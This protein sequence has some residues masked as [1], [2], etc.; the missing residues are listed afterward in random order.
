MKRKIEKRRGRTFRSYDVRKD[1]SAEQLAAVG[2]VILAWNDTE[3][4]LNVLMCVVCN[5]H[6]GIWRDLASRIQGYEGKIELVK[7]TV[8]A[9][10]G[11]REN[12]G[13]LHDAI[14]LTLAAVKQGR[15]HRDTL[16]HTRVIDRYLGI[17]ETSVRRT[18]LQEILLT[19]DALNGLYDHI[20]A[21]TKELW[22]LISFFEQLNQLASLGEDDKPIGSFLVDLIS[23]QQ[24]A[25]REG[26]PGVLSVTPDLSR[27]SIEQEAQRCFSQY[28]HH[29]NQRLL[30]KPLPKLPPE[31]PNQPLPAEILKAMKAAPIV[32][33]QSPGGESGAP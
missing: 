10:F 23:A 5:I 12:S 29:H 19:A 13:W 9:R 15:Q 26:K 7:L 1:L 22:W 17:G 6:H 32:P 31:D 33:T 30:L 25:M 8:S 2:S 28:H 16:A 4:M 11:I 18:E 24:A 3:A 21:L 14:W 27:R 20:H